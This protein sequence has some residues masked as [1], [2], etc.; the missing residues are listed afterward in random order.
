MNKI[1]EKKYNIV[2]A[3][4]LVILFIIYCCESSRVSMWLDDILQIG[5]VG[6]EIP[7]ENFLYNI[8]NHD[9]QPPMAHIV[10]AIWT[11]IAPYGNFW[12]R[13]PSII[14]VSLGSVICA[15]VVKEIEGSLTAI[16]VFFGFCSISSIYGIIIGL[17][18][19][20]IYSNNG[21]LL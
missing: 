3:I 16:F 2:I 7:K 11:R 6:K 5:M 18:S 14:F 19:L 15:K 13:L 12:M 17:S 4:S 9:L 8:I 1:S 21:F 20:S 10:T